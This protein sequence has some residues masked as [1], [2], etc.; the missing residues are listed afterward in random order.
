[1]GQKVRV[2]LLSQ[3]QRN[4]ELSSIK[5]KNYRNRSVF[6]SLVI[7][8]ENVTILPQNYGC[9][10]FFG[11]ILAAGRNCEVDLSEVYVRYLTE[12]HISGVKY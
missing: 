5:N 9:L 8:L 1:M 2:L 7:V 3:L 11:W 4:S 10:V 12:W 6:F